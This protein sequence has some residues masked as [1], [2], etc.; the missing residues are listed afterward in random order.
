MRALTLFDVDPGSKW[1]DFDPGPS[2]SQ[3]HFEIA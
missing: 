1:G 2:Q 3:K